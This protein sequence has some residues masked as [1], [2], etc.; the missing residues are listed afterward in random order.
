MFG[1]R[2]AIN[3]DTI[4]IGAFR[5]DDTGLESGS[6]YV[7]TRTGRVWAQ[8]EKLTASDG[9]SNAFFGWSVAVDG[10]T[11]VIGAVFDDDN[12]DRS[13]SAYVFTRI[14]TVWTLQEK[15]TASDG[16]SGDS[17]GFSVA[18]NGDTIVIGA[19]F[20]D[21]NGI[22]SGSAYVF[23][24]TGTVWALQGKK[25][26]A[27]DGAS[28][29][30]FGLSVAVNG[31]TIVVGAFLDDDNGSDS[32]NAYVFIRTGTVWAL[33]EKLTA[34]DGTN[35]DP[36]GLSVAVNGDTI[37]IGARLD[38]DNGSN[39]GSAYVFTRTGTVWTLQGK[40]T[41]S[42][43]ASEDR[44]G[45]SVAVNGD[46]IVIGAN[47]DD[48]TANESGSA[49]V[50]TRTGTVW[51][52]ER[53]LI[54]I[55][56]AFFGIYVA[57]DGDT[58]VIGANG[59]VDGSDNGSAYIFETVAPAL[60]I[61]E[62]DKLTAS[63]GAAEDV[64]GL[65]VA[66][67]GDTIVIGAS[68]DDD[69][70][71]ESGSVYV[72]TRTGTLWALQGKLTP[73]DGAPDD[74]FGGHVAVDGDT[75]VVG[76][77]GDDDNGLDSGSVYVYTRTGTVWALQGKLT[78]RDG[79]V[80]DRF[81]ESVTVDGD[82]IVSGARE[83]DDNGI[84]SGSA[85]VFTRTGTVWTQQGKLTASDGASDDFFGFSVAINGDTIVI[86]AFR[87]DDNGFN[88]GSAY[89]FTR[90]GTV[91]ALQEKLTA[92]DGASEDLFGFSV[93]INGDTIVIGAF[94]DDDARIDSGSA[95]VFTRT[96]M[97]W[98]QQGKLTA[99]DGSFDDLFGFSV[100]VSEDTIVIGTRLDDDNGSD[101]G[102]AYVFT[103]TGTVWAQQGKLTA[104]DGASGDFFG[105]SVAIDEDTIVIGAVFDD[106]NGDQSGSAYV[107]DI[108]SE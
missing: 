3:G 4:V 20:D 34:S 94:R 76:A 62:M 48:D 55:S 28:I 12:G 41:A 65:S 60:I 99:S 79:A 68:R 92:G 58:I 107:F 21:D 80:G 44:F 43:G 61:V 49:Y 7:F 39:S 14:G 31:D 23:T 54:A 26:T 17:F 81:G 50:F 29:D 102:S 89:V 6:A 87:D 91:W 33:Q 27:S 25:I 70:G 45:S 42:D 90:T 11:I 37:V 66:V 82:T 105:A 75:I 88:S 52:L 22:D 53:K 1:R 78:A 59:D 97:V 5:D 18:I 71:L 103:R 57:V 56:D 100:A 36:F 8:Q 2:V 74:L 69:N 30:R 72:F 86:G 101:S 96:G 13:G 67:S 46:T 9:A 84:D 32:G 35:D 73:S 15:F 104:S 106:D 85:F 98:T 64:F 38:D 77:L 51:A 63:G 108:L 47:G 40:L 16:A 93:A 19:V 83:D 10:D 24:R 95:Y